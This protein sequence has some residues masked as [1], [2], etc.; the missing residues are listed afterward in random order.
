MKELALILLILYAN[1]KEPYLGILNGERV[2]HFSLAL[3]LV[4]EQDKSHYAVNRISTLKIQQFIFYV[5]IL[6]GEASA[7]DSYLIKA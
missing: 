6:M 1:R 4:L 7:Q 3:N 5:L 2:R